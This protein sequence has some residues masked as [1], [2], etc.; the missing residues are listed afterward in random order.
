MKID[1]FKEISDDAIHEIIY[2]LKGEKFNRGEILMEPGDNASTLYFL[3]D[4]V[5]EVFT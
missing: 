3:Q 1:F 5:I 2:N 4:G